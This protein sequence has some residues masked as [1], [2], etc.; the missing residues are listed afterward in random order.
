MVKIAPHINSSVD[1]AALHDLEEVLT[2]IKTNEEIS[3]RLSLSNQ[4]VQLYLNRYI[5]TFEFSNDEI[6]SYVSEQDIEAICKNSNLI[7]YYAEGRT[8]KEILELYRKTYKRPDDEKN[9][10]DV[11]NKI[12]YR[13]AGKWFRY[14]SDTKII[15]IKFSV[16]WETR[17]WV[18]W[19]QCDPRRGPDWEYST[20]YIRSTVSI[21]MSTNT[22]IKN[23]DLKPN[24]FDS[25]H[26]T[27][28]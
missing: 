16:D 17:R 26:S 18:P 11:I 28:I 15:E 25:S 12:V 27:F 3:E 21:D 23:E 13:S 5:D 10:V 14:D 2:A 9:F 7:G 8:M 19:G 22:I 6:D 24:F 4:N 1:F 20:K